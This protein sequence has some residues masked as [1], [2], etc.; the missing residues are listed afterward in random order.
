MTFWLFYTKYWSE[1]F[2]KTKQNWYPKT[3][4]SDRYFV[5]TKN[6]TDILYRQKKSVRLFVCTK[7]W[8]R[9]LSIQNIGPI[10]CICL[11]IFLYKLKRITVLV[12]YK[13]HL[14]TTPFS[15]ENTEWIL[16][17]FCYKWYCILYIYVYINCLLFIVYIF[18]T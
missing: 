2:F 3:N 10:A 12:L 6:L 17:L 16:C 1:I 18:L 11:P 5:Q 8:F 9:L 13:K 14:R 7:E 4:K 15:Q